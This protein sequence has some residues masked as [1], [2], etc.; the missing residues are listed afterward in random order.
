MMNELER[1]KCSKRI[2][3]RSNFC[4]MFYRISENE[5]RSL[6]HYIRLLPKTIKMLRVNILYLYCEDTEVAEAFAKEAEKWNVELVV[7][8]IPLEDLP[9]RQIIEPIITTC[10]KFC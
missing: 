10:K 5:K 4:T 9:T 6:T 2:D 1:R 8:K 7:I 3:R